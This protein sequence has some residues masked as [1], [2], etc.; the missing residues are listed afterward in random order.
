MTGLYVFRIPIS[1]HNWYA[2]CSLGQFSAVGGGTNNCAVD[3]N[4]FVGGGVNNSAGAKASFIGGGDTN[5]IDPAFGVCAVIGGGNLNFNGSGFG[6]IGGGQNNIL[7]G[8]QFNAILGGQNN[9]DAGLAGVMIAGNNITAV[10]PDTLHINGL[11]ANGIPGPGSGGAIP[12]TV[13]W[14]YISS[15]PVPFNSCQILMI[16]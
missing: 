10:N 5:V 8:D 4:S 7:S 14:Q 13:Y 15:L 6:V 1:K 3:I 2:N 11:W 16:A 9:N 12:G